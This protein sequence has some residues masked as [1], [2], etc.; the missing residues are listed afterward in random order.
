MHLVLRQL[1]LD[2]ALCGGGR[3]GPAW[4]CAKSGTLGSSGPP[5][6]SKDTFY[7][8]RSELLRSSLAELAGK[9]HIGAELAAERATTPN[10]LHQ[11]DQRAQDG[12]QQVEEKGRGDREAVDRVA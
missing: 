9:H 7:T 2:S 4:A 11:C 6:A 10:A 1:S 8:T 5:A 3:L 12:Q